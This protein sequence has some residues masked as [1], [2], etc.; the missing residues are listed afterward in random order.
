MMNS[1][2]K[3]DMAQT[4]AGFGTLLKKPPKPAKQFQSLHHEEVKIPQL[5]PPIFRNTLKVHTAAT[6][7]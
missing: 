5:L 6:L 7:N 1:T 2:A 3:L 4:M